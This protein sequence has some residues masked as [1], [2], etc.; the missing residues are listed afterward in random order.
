MDEL[1]EENNEYQQHSKKDATCLYTITPSSNILVQGNEIEKNNTTAVKST[2]N[3]RFTCAIVFRLSLDRLNIHIL[4]SVT[5][6]Q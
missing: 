5:R 1:K 2:C 3:E 4:A 6:Q